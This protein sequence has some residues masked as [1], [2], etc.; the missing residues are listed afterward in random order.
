MRSIG[1]SIA[2]LVIMPLPSSASPGLTTFDTWDA[3]LLNMSGARDGESSSTI[4]F[5]AD[6]VTSDGLAVY[7]YGVVALKKDLEAEG[8]TVTF[9]DSPDRRAY[10]HLYSATSDPII[11]FAISLASGGVIL[12][13]QSLAKIRG[14][15]M[16]R[17]TAMRRIHRGSETVEEELT[18]EGTARK[19][20]DVVKAW[21]DQPGPDV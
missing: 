19:S 10:R 1:E 14:D 15:K 16:V 6:H 4:H 3:I 2:K 12:A 8:I 5:T 13:I 7:A 18:Y 21:K 11:Q 17:I 20:V 9:A